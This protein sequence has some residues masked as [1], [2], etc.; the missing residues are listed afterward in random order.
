MDYHKTWY[1]RYE[2]EYLL[3]IFVILTTYPKNMAD[4]QTCGGA[5]QP[6][7]NPGQGWRNFL[8]KRDQIV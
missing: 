3:L 1:M 7:L 5:V 6:T 2:I 4:L 8:M